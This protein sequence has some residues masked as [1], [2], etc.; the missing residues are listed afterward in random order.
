MVEQYDVAAR[1]HQRSAEILESA[2]ECDDAGYHYGLVGEMAIKHALRASGCEA[3]WLR[4]GPKSHAKLR[5]TPMGAHV[6]DMGARISEA[7]QVIRLFASGRLAQP[8]MSLLLHPSFQARFKGWH[9]NIR[10]ADT[11]HTPVSATDLERYRADAAELLQHLI[12]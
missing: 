2:N 1:R 9:I 5:A 8:I 4:S 10:Y 12:A 3:K 6:Q 7:S 11:M